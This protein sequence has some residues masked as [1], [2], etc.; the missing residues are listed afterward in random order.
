MAKSTSL[1]VPQRFKVRAFL[2]GRRSAVR[3]DGVERLDHLGPDTDL[4]IVTDRGREVAR[5][6][7]SVDGLALG[8][9]LKDK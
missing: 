7:L 4:D 1:S 2:R 6:N 8:E 5:G 3:A 9:I